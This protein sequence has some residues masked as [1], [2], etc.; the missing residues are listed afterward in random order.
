V[1]VAVVREILEPLPLSKSV[2][3]FTVLLISWLSI[4]EQP[5]PRA[6]MMDVSGSVAARVVM[7]LSHDM[8]HA[9]CAQL[10]HKC[11]LGNLARR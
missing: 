7:T 8:L 3:S 5:R 10:V 1:V 4:Y 6:L 11:G 2:E 9:A